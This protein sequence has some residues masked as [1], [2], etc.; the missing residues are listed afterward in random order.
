MKRL[1][2]YKKLIKVNTTYKNKPKIG[3]FVKIWE[4][5]KYIFLH[6]TLYYSMYLKSDHSIFFLDNRSSIELKN[7]DCELWQA[8]MPSIHE[9]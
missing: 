3:Y 7:E 6:K 2:K 8:S 9:L 1:L 4:T 5:E